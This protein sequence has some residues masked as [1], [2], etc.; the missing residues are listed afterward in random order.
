[1]KES[2]FKLIESINQSSNGL[3][4]DTTNTLGSDRN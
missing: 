2:H 3:E 4:A 1:M